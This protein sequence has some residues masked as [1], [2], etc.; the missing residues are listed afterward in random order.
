MTR[1]RCSRR[2]CENRCEM[3]T[4]SE[5]KEPIKASERV[6]LKQI[7][8]LLTILRVIIMKGQNRSLTTA[9]VACKSECKLRKYSHS[10][11]RLISM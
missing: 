9:I 5:D 2:Q 8:Q 10:I 1:G 4:L 6:G 3:L 7:T 11:I